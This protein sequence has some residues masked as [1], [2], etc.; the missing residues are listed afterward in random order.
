VL[1]I[2]G[3]GLGFDPTTAIT[4]DLLHNSAAATV[5][6]TFPNGT[7][8]AFTA[9]GGAVNPSSAPTVAAVASTTFTRATGGIIVT[10]TLDQQTVQLAVGVG[11]TVPTLSWQMLA[12]LGLA[13]ALLGFLVL[14]R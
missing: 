14:R 5:S 11:P 3:P 1:S 2:A 9:V 8:I 4:A 12:A 10:A 7:S 13:M 6:P